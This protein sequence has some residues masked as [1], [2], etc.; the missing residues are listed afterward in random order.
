MSSSVFQ[1]LLHHNHTKWREK[2]EIEEVR[3]YLKPTPVTPKGI[4]KQFHSGDKL[5]RNMYRINDANQAR[6]WKPLEQRVRNSS[7]MMSFHNLARLQSSSSYRNHSSIQRVM[8]HC[9]ILGPFYCTECLKHA[10]RYMYDQQIARTFPGIDLTG[11]MLC[12]V[13]ERS[14]KVSYGSPLAFSLSELSFGTFYKQAQSAWYGSQY[15]PDVL[16]RRQVT[17]QYPKRD[18]E[19]NTGRDTGRMIKQDDL[20]QSNGKHRKISVR[21]VE[22]SQSRFVK[23]QNSPVVAKDKNMERSQGDVEEGKVVDTAGI[24]AFCYINNVDYPREN[25]SEAKQRSR[26]IILPD[27]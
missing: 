15:D 12:M 13:R 22:K 26:S 5:R 10:Q 16:E 17:L 18:E 27:F 14:D 3:K 20:T 21:F 4:S 7:K 1:Q 6:M 23:R 24:E 19:V 25:T 8:H 9:E 11:R 2:A